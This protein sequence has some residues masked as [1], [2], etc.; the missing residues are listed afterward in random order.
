MTSSFAPDRGGKASPGAAAPEAADAVVPAPVQR[1]LDRGLRALAESPGSA[2]E[3][4]QEP[5]T[6]AAGQVAQWNADG[7]PGGLLP[8]RSDS[9]RDHP[10]QI[11][12]PGGCLEREDETAEVTALREAREE[13]GLGPQ[14][15]RILGR[16][17]P[18]RTGTGFL[19][20]PIAAV[21]ATPKEWR[22]RPCPQ[23]VA[24]V[25][26]FPL[27]VLLDERAHQRVTMPV[28]DGTPMMFPAFRWEGRLIWGATAG[29]L[30]ELAHLIWKGDGP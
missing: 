22:P 16:M 8:R 1:S 27:Q 6:P 5:A 9:L 21:V 30:V 24:E 25:F 13:V 10:G 18:Y 15:V 29:I 26:S 7:A 12:F 17:T 3:G 2:E 20:F 14:A 28:E 4:L 23:E 11:S 19:I